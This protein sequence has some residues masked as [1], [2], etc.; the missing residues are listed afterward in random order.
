M[1][2]EVVTGPRKFFP[3]PDEQVRVFA[4]G[5]SA[6]EMLLQGGRVINL[7]AP[8]LLSVQTTLRGADNHEA[9][10]LVQLRVRVSSVEQ[11]LEIANP[12]AACER[13]VSTAVIAAATNMQL[14]ALAK[15]RGDGTGGGLAAALQSR[16]EAIDFRRDLADSLREHAA[17]DLRSFEFVAVEPSESLQKLLKH[18]ENLVA[19]RLQEKITDE[20]LA[21]A[22]A[23][24]EKEHQVEAIKQAH[25]LKLRADR[26]Q[27]KCKVDAVQS[28]RELK[29]LRELKGMGVDLTRYLVSRNVPPRSVAIEGEVVDSSGFMGCTPWLEVK[30]A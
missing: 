7:R 15:G 22:A 13:L 26:D 21:A 24:Q 30:R 29:H 25:E 8:A 3:E 27:A 18:E 11:A 5:A 14:H 16:F 2:Q 28:E 1:S 9:Q 4:W 6:N 12:L 19:S 20:A 10:V 17:C 23:R